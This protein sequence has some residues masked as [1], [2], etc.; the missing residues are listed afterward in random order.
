[1]RNKRIQKWKDY[2]LVASS[3]RYLHTKHQKEADENVKTYTDAMD[4][5]MDYNEIEFRFMRL[6]HKYQ[7]KADKLHKRIRRNTK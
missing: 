2:E 5:V 4:F 7:K 1:M 3:L 6:I